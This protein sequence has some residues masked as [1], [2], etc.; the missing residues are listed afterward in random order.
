MMLSYTKIDFM[1]SQQKCIYAV[2]KLYPN[3]NQPQHSLYSTICN[4]E[5]TMNHKDTNFS[6]K[7]CNALDKNLESMSINVSQ[8]LKKS[9]M[10]ALSEKKPDG[11]KLV[12]NAGLGNS[13][14]TGGIFNRRW[15]DR[16]LCF[17]LPALVLVIGI[18]TIYESV[19]DRRIVDLAEID[20]AV[21]SDVLPLS[22]Y[23]DP[24]FI[25]FLKTNFPD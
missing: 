21:L 14:I 5:K 13:T 24:G 10:L 9:R 15:I 17:Y 20:S 2:I 18:S 22:A 3:K 12:L 8:R 23:T 6:H 25:Q 19:K 7:I 1:M 4:I 16:Q 11:R